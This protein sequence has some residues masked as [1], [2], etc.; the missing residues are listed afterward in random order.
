MQFSSSFMAKGKLLTDFHSLSEDI[1]YLHLFKINSYGTSLDYSIDMKGEKLSLVFS[2]NMIS[3]S[4]Y[5]DTLSD[6]YYLLN[7]S[8]FIRLI[9]YLKRHY[10]IDFESVYPY[11]S[12]SISI[13]LDEAKLGYF[14]SEQKVKGNI[15][16]YLDNLSESNFNLSEKL[17]QINRYNKD[18]LSELSIYKK[19]SQTVASNLRKANFEN[20]SLEEAASRSFGIDIK[21]AHAVLK[22][23]GYL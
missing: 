1:S 7:F 6:N 22:S 9:N 8:R 19:F 3:Y 14:K 18:I 17:I 21:L 20:D 2:T 4:F 10:R 15:L 5:Y 12:N 23:L 16:E 13:K 11:L